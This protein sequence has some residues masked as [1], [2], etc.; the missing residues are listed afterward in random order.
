MPIEDPDDL[1]ESSDSPVTLVPPRASALKAALAPVQLRP[2]GSSGGGRLQ[3][4]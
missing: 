3:L 4:A 2:V 1:I